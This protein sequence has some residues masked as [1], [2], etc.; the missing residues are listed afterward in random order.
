MPYICRV[1]QA[2]LQSVNEFCNQCGWKGT[3]L[4]IASLPNQLRLS[5]SGTSYA[6]IS[7][8]K[9][10]NASIK[11]IVQLQSDNGWVT[12]DKDAK[13]TISE[14]SFDKG[15]DTVA[16]RLYFHIGTY[17]QSRPGTT[18]TTLNLIITSDDAQASDLG[19][20]FH[21]ATAKGQILRRPWQIQQWRKQQVPI[22]L[23][24]K[25]PAKLEIVQ[26]AI[27][28]S[29]SNERKWIHIK[30]SGHSDL[31]LQKV[32]LPS[33]FELWSAGAN[34]HIVDVQKLIGT[35][36]EQGKS[37]NYFVRASG[38]LAARDTSIEVDAGSAGKEE[39]EVLVD[40]RKRSDSGALSNYVV[41]VDFGTSKT[42]VAYLDVSNNEVSLIDLESSGHMPSCMLIYRSSRSGSAPQFGEEEELYGTEAI[43][44][45]GY[46]LPDTVGT[47]I[48]SMKSKLCQD[49]PFPIL[50]SYTLTPQEI[51]I[52]YLR[53]VRRRIRTKVPTNGGRRFVF[54]LPVL[55]I[56]EMESDTVL[57]NSA[58]ERQQMLTLAAADKA[59]FKGDTETLLEPQ[60][61][62]LYIAHYRDT[63][64]WGV[65]L[66]A[67]ELFAVYDFGAGTLDITFAQYQL[68][69]DS[70]PEIKPVANIGRY[71][72]SSSK[73]AISIGGDLIDRVVATRIIDQFGLQ[74]KGKAIDDYE[75][76]ERAEEVSS[77]GK[78]ARWPVFLDE[79]R[80]VK[81]QF[82][83][84]SI[85][86]VEVKGPW[87]TIRLER[88]DFDHWVSPLINASIRAMLKKLDAIADTVDDELKYIFLI[89]GSSLMPIVAQ[90]MSDEFSNATVVPPPSKEDAL[91]A[92]VKGAALSYVIRITNN[93]GHEVGIRRPGTE[94]PQ[95]K[96]FA[97]NVL[98]PRA[99][100]PM[101][102]P[103]EHMSGMW[104]VVFARKSKWYRFG[105]A[106]IP[107]SR[108]ADDYITL[109]FKVD[110]QRRIFMSYTF[111]KDMAL[112]SAQPVFIGMI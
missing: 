13:R 110:E 69:D 108:I 31:T 6:D 62:A 71:S 2:E 92:V 106:P 70:T 16:I 83:D 74:V 87:D 20:T 77:V 91:L 64:R 49:Q 18:E 11:V 9:N 73:P 33:G 50:Q 109:N 89:G 102:Q 47:F 4:I 42:A 76:I 57:E 7:L 19:A 88:T 58:Y 27:L 103:A 35:T 53:E 104:E 90:R 55:D 79:V 85:D 10:G 100:D 107:E 111:T 3:E 24:F 54:S 97:S 51:V 45:Y 22:G 52:R 17:L 66:Q 67:G 56:E 63:Q 5:K 95:H 34:S 112:N 105:Y 65:Q 98:L 46:G 28:F 40:V 37:M 41:A 29:R 68:G 75:I 101:V 93:L 82:S 61:A 39:I 60:C 12:F 1:C 84:L 30:N 44:R 86:A 14:I 15:K 21:E 78:T 36:I 38:A 99:T 72:L 26:K 96:V 94:E 80:R 25:A 43:N 8:G 32:Y 23:Q 81:E 48:R 59:G